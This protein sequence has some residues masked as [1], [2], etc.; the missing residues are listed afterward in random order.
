MIYNRTKIGD[1][2]LVNIKVFPTCFGSGLFQGN[3]SSCEFYTFT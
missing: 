3:L 2:E 1:P